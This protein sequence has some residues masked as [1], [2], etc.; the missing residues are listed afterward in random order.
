MTDDITDNDATDLPAGDDELGAI[1]SMVPESEDIADRRGRRSF[2]DRTTRRS[3]PQK[4]LPTERSGLNRM[5]DVLVPGLVVVT[6]ALALFGIIYLYKQLQQTQQN[7]VAATAR[8]EQLEARLVSTDTTLTKSEVLLGA[9][10]KS[11]DE[12]IDSNKSEVHKLWGVTEKNTRA[13]QAQNTEVQ[14]QKTDLQ[15]VTEQAQQTAGQLATDS[16]L[17]KNVDSTVK[18]AAQR[19]EIVQESLSDLNTD[20]K[21]LKDKQVHL[22]SDMGKRVTTLEDTAKST[23][24]FRRNT[25]DEL[26]K[27]HEELSKQQVQPAVGVKSTP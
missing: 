22:E 12:L 3:L 18:E 4:K 7:L 10:L 19:M 2:I 8:V 17:L 27:L 14:Q 20:T 5:Q 24:V 1:P 21:S 9:K 15:S 23:D 25:L 11:M 13:L 16:A 26:R 6:L